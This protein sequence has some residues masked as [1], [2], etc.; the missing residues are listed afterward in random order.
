MLKEIL[1]GKPLEDLQGIDLRDW[2]RRHSLS[3]TVMTQGG[4]QIHLCRDG[5]W[6]GGFVDTLRPLL[7][8]QGLGKVVE[9]SI[10]AWV[11]TSE[12]FKGQRLHMDTIE[13]RMVIQTIPLTE[14][15]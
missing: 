8:G 6:A 1:R 12:G 9:S 7:E 2:S 10:L 5:E 11:G 4:L 15:G 14:E 13:T 3:Q